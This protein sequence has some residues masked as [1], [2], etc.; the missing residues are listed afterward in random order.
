MLYRDKLCD[1]LYDDYVCIYILN[2]DLSHTH[3]CT[4]TYAPTHGHTHKHSCTY[5]HSTYMH[6]HTHTYTDTHAHTRT[7]TYRC[8]VYHTIWCNG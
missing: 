1:E 2:T 7:P 5:S 6:T 4:H 8:Q 3:A